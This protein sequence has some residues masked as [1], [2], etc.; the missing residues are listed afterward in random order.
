MTLKGIPRVVGHP[1]TGNARALQFDP[2]T[3]FSEAGRAHG[4]MA[5]INFFGWDT[6]FVNTAPLVQEVLVEKAA[7]FPKDFAFRILFHPTI[8]NGLFTSIGDIWRRQRKLVAPT[9]QPQQ[10]S[11]YA[12]MMPGFSVRI[13]ER[14]R[15]GLYINA[16]H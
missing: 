13:S 15:D 7:R 8:G 14:W 6:L 2:I 4:D 3:L 16:H 1:V 9:F 10:V 5:R 11:R 12:Q